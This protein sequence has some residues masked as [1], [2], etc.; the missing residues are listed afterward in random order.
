MKTAL[1]RMKDQKDIVS[2]NLREIRAHSVE[3]LTSL[4][5]SEDD[6]KILKGTKLENDLAKAYDE[7]KEKYDNILQK[8]KSIK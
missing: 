2:R 6:K 1:S 4:L 8:S 3:A 5:L 7:R